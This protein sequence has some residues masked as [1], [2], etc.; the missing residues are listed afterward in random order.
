LNDSINYG[1]GYF[2]GQNDRESSNSATG[3]TDTNN[4]TAVVGRLFVQPFKNT[5]VNLLSGLGVGYAASYEPQANSTL[6]DLYF[7][8]AV[9]PFLVMGVPGTPGTTTNIHTDGIHIRTS[10]QASYYYN[11]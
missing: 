9:D 6:A 8:R 10:P 11:L 2:N 3:H 5:S 1:V 4:D 7:S